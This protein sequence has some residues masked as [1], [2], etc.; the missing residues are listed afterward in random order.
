MA[1]PRK[2]PGIY[3]TVYLLAAGR[4]DVFQQAVL[5]AE[6]ALHGLLDFFRGGH[7]VEFVGE[8]AG[9]VDDERPRLAGKAPLLDR[10]VGRPR[11]RVLEDL[12]VDEVGAVAVSIRHRLEDLELRPA[13][14]AA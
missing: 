9:G 4:R 10:G 3:L 5:L 6:D 14:L 7:A 12:D 11:L 13:G 1:C 2:R 8:V